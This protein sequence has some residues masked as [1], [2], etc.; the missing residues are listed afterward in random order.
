MHIA[1]HDRGRPDRR[2]VAD[3]HLAD[4]GRG[5]IDIDARAQ[6]G[7]DIAVGSNVH[8]APPITARDLAVRLAA[9]QRRKPRRNGGYFRRGRGGALES[10]LALAAFGRTFPTP[11]PTAELD[12]P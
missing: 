7:R 12:L 5:R 10:A 11:M 1:A 8:D 3:P 2:V 6:H 4:D 9:A